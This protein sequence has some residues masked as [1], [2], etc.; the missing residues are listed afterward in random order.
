MRKAILILSLLILCALAFG[1]GGTKHAGK[2]GRASKT[3]PKPSPKPTPDQD[4]PWYSPCG[5][6]Y[7]NIADFV[8]SMEDKWQLIGETN[9]EF[10]W[11]N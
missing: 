8:D 2:V 10:L 6:Y 4:K 7:K 5:V 9:D 1:Q 11:C 3:K